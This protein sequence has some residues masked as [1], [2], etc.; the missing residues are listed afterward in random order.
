MHRIAPFL[1]VA[2][3][4]A[5]V[6]AQ[7]TMTPL[8][9]FG[10]NG[11]LAPGSSAFLTTGNSERGLAFNPVTG[12]LVLVSRAG[13]N[14]VRVLHGATGADQGGFD[15]TGI[16]GGTFA[17][18]MAGV[19]DD[20][21]IYVANLSTSAASPFKVYAWPSEG[22][23]PTTAPTVAYNAV[24]GVV[25]TGDAFAIMGSGAATRF[26]AAGSTTTSNGSFVIGPVDGTNASTAYLSV[27]GT[28]SGTTNDYRLSMTWVDANTVI[29]TQGGTAR[30]TEISGASAAVTAQIPLGATGRR[31]LDYAVV[32][33]VPVLAVADSGTS[34]V[35]I[36]DL[37]VPGVPTLLVQGNNTTGT[38]SANANGTGSVQWGAI[39]G[40]TATLYAM[41][42]NQGI[43]AF[44]VT[45]QPPATGK[46]FGLG[47]PGV[48]PVTL[49]AIGA[50]VLPS[51]I[52]LEVGNL[53]ATAPV[54]F[55]VFGFA[56]IP[57]GVQI[58]I[59]LQGCNQYLHPFTT[60]F[61]VSG[62]NPTFQMAQSFPAAPQFA[63]SALFVQ[64]A[65]IDQPSTILVSNGLRLYLETF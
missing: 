14:H 18:N 10:T 29:G 44:Q 4:S 42:T 13:G 65:T 26:A 56:G 62:G 17:I 12:N 34:Q 6:L 54:G 2:A 45:I 49:S 32:G 28:A 23:G 38:L 15:V 11:W 48:S 24:S 41:V 55:Y 36:F 9:G 47:C 31:S 8:A 37:S 57:Q 5:T 63:G 51:T 3:L 58:P 53:P 19:G 22:A 35:S 25:R 39:S 64:V 43:Q 61:F 60:V 20:G 7:S 46:P 50:P 59:A 52:Q 30:W 21:A 1:A 16:T 40:N 33:G 27:P